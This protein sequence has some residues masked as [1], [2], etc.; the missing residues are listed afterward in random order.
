MD[1]NLMEIENESLKKLARHDFQSLTG[2]IK[3]EDLEVILRDEYVKLNG[4]PSWA[5]DKIDSDDEKDRQNE[6]D[7]IHG[8]VVSS[9]KNN[10]QIKPLYDANAECKLPS[11]SDCIEFHPTKN[12]LVA[13]GKH[14]HMQLF[15]VNNDRCNCIKTLKLQNFPVYCAHFVRS[16]SE[17][18]LSSH[19]SCLYIYD[20]EK[21][22]GV[23]LDRILGRSEKAWEKFS[24]SPCGSTMAM[25]GKN[26]QIPI[27][28]L[29]TRN[30]IGNL[31]QGSQVVDIAYSKHNENTLYSIGSCGD[32]YVWDF[33]TRRCVNK[34]VNY[35]LYDAN[36]LSASNDGF[37]ATG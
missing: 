20:V 3:T 10:I 5:E 37:I 8:S 7:L 26:G 31:T 9:R 35:S 12:I 24:V 21:E 25:V 29:K 18:V 4:V 2:Q 36:I 33:R 17:I 28:S 13:A 11:P 1:F 19:R 16:G 34:I 6:F 30:V 22:Q 32:I 14:T 27:V 15:D 23:Y